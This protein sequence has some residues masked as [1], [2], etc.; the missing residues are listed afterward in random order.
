MDPNFITQTHAEL[1]A[2]ILQDYIIDRPAA[3]ADEASDID[4]KADILAGNVKHCQWRQAYILRQL[5][6]ESADM[7]YLILAAKNN[8]GVI[9]GDGIRAQ[10]Y[11]K[12]SRST[13]AGANLLIPAGTVFTS[14]PDA[15]GNLIRAALLYNATIFTG[16]TYVIGIA[17]IIEIQAETPLQYEIPS[18]AGGSHVVAVQQLGSGISGNIQDGT[19]I[20]FEGAPPTGVEAVVNVSPGTSEGKGLDASTT[21]TIVGGVND[22][23]RVNINGA[24]AQLITLTAGVNLSGAVVSADIQAKIRSVGGG[25]LSLALCR[26]NLTGT[27]YSFVIFSGIPG[28]G[29]SVAVTAG[30]HDAS[31]TLGFDAVTELPGGGGFTGGL[32]PQSKESLRAEYLTALQSGGEAGT[33]SD[34]GLWALKSGQGVDSA[35]VIP[36]TGGVAILPLSDSGVFFSQTELDAITAYIE[37]RCPVHLVGSIIVRNPTLSPVYIQGTLTLDDTHTLVGVTPAVKLAIK[38]YLKTLPLQGTIFSVVR[39]TQIAAAILSAPGVIDVTHLTIGTVSPPVGT[40]NLT[41]GSGEVWTTDDAKI[42][43]L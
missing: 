8:A 41:A 27:D 12:L 2:Q 42:T 14:Q 22:Q 21:F 33:A 5:F 4:I 23:I 19:L 1:K 3:D 20:S 24:G 7:P 30:T 43:L 26:W 18:S 37:T 31:I 6:A 32:D 10:G 35:K 29:S 9:W 40:V 39:F 17:E 11:V 36:L 28:A 13:P 38:E 16:Q 25:G 15:N 34:Y